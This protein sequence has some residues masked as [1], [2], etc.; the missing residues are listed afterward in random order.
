M[1][2]NTA[3]HASLSELADI[4]KDQHT[5]K[6][7]IVTTVDNIGFRDGTLVVRD[8][9][10]QI[11]P[12]GVTPT[13]GHYR[14]TD[15]FTE[16]VAGKLRIP[17][18]YLKRLH[19][20]APYLYDANVNGLLHGRTVRRAGAAP[21]VVKA[22]D[23]RS[24]LLRC[25][26]SDETGTGIARAFLS[27]QYQLVDNLDV[28][29][30]ALDGI[31]ESGVEATPVTCDLTDRKMHVRV[32]A[33]G[34][35][36]MADTLLAGYRSPFDDPEVN[37]ERG[38]GAQQWERIGI[39]GEPHVFAG[40][41]IRNSETGDGAFTLVPVVTISTCQNGLTLTQEAYRK[42][43][44]GRKMDTGSIDWSD[45]TQRK[46]LEL[47]RAQTRD[48]V[49]TFLDQGWLNRQVAKLEEKAAA[50]VENADKA[51]R[52]VGK[53]LQYSEQEVAGV[54]DHFIR[55]GQLTA[56]GVANAVTSYAQTVIDADRSHDLEDSAVRALELVAR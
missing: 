11:T 47:V 28:L 26:R 24:F 34:V 29:T 52:T 50:R 21:E 36:A 17:A 56:G 1:N 32:A 25:F 44:L 55:G 41:D 2:T 10:P 45:D 43:H 39:D 18:G 22:P 51:I 37:R 53:T 30:A 9:E 16:G 20:E 54:L 49:A 42:V 40:F 33:P 14:P 27:D 23:A 4:L 3:R 6:L 35:Q 12:D 7:D 48:A 31:R 5:R 19:G 15:V 38:G 8:A 46:N 13:N